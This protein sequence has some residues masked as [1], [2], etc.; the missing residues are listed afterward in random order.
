MPIGNSPEENIV[1]EE[2]KVNKDTFTL[3]YL[4][5]KIQI[6]LVIFLIIPM[7]ASLI[8]FAEL[9]NF[10]IENYNFYFY[11]YLSLLMLVI[12]IHILKIFDKGLIFYK[13][14]FLFL[15]GGLLGF[16]IGLIKVFI[17]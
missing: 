1:I 12:G 9:I 7:I 10:L 13:K 17:E 2:L 5:N 11:R 4:L 14:G 15:L 3:D 6:S 16:L 8:L